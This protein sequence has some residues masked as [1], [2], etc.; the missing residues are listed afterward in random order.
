M[1][2]RIAAA[3]RDVLY[4]EDSDFFDGDDTDLRELGLDSVRFVLVMKQ[5]GVDRE[6]DAVPRLADELTVAAWV[7]VL[8]NLDGLG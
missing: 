7:R 5:L 1:R 4:V 6:S 3:V 2:D 8:G